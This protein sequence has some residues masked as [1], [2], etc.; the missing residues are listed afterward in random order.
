MTDT[1]TESSKKRRR[2][3]RSKHGKDPDEDVEA[4]GEDEKQV[5][6]ESENDPYNDRDDGRGE[7]DGDDDQEDRGK[8]E[9][10]KNQ[11]DDGD[12]E[13]EK[14]DT[15]KKRKRKRKRNKKS[16]EDASGGT[17]AKDSAADS[18][19]SKQVSAEYTVFIEG[20]PF[21]STEDDIRAFFDSHGCQDILQM[22]LPK[23]QDSGRLRGFGHVVFNS[24]ESKKRALSDEVNGKDIGGRYI[25]IKEAN[26]PRPGTTAGAGLGAG[27]IRE[28]P[29]NC[30]TVFVKN[31]PYHA[32]EEDILESMRVCGKIL[33]DGVRVVRNNQNGQ[34]K[35]FAYVEYKT[36][37]GALA[38]VQKAAKPFGMSVLGR[39]VF[40]DYDEGH[41]KGSFRGRDGKLWTKEHPSNKDS[42]GGR[43]RS[44]F[45]RGSGRGFG[46]GRGSK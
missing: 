32:T 6:N 28:Q 26:V 16:T 40:V 39:P 11:E 41:V 25:A 13:K 20:L 12:E 45:G 14:D 27:G 43:G 31:L 29:E 10:S 7:G 46:W 23:W 42:S 24:M 38:A 35:G 21:T 22:R 4:A 34:S 2:R 9:H 33:D 17:T 18:D 1:A 30:K 37:E 44:G 5:S 19:V 36:M 8:I 15:T 3:K